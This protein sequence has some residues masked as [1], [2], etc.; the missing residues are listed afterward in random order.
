[1]EFLGCD[2]AYIAYLILHGTEGG[3]LV[4]LIYLA[5][6]FAIQEQQNN[7]YNKQNCYENNRF[8]LAYMVKYVKTKRRS[9]PL[10]NNPVS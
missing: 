2:A 10:Y 4:Y 3:R 9:T 6:F 1:M 7:A 5:Y 8:I